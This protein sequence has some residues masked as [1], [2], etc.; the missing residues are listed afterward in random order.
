MK[1][2]TNTIKV[3]QNFAGINQNI[4]VH[5]N[6]C[7]LKTVSEAKNIM[8]C[9]SIEDSIDATFGIYDLNEFLSA[10][11]LVNTPDFTFSDSHIEVKSENAKHGIRYFC[12]NPEILTYPK[13][14]ITNPAYEVQFVLS[15]EDINAIK[16]AASIFGFETVSL[17]KQSDSND[18]VAKVVD[19]NNK[20]SNA[21]NLVVGTIDDSSAFSFN[22]MIS[23]LKLIP[24][25]YTVSL[26]SKFISRWQS[27]FTPSVT[28]WIALESTSSYTK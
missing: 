16:K 20:S 26:S 3:L 18:I 23:N 11:T 19:N 1:L 10:I 22:F 14:D 27:A 7:L 17:T 13:K 2:S 4:V 6:T 24:G 15:Q 12:A 5:K 21:Y 8:A 28:Y 9:A 25:D